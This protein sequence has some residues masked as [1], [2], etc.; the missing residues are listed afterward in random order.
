M[1]DEFEKKEAEESAEEKKHTSSSKRRSRRS[2]SPTFGLIA[3]VIFL[4]LF[5]ALY[6]IVTV[7]SLATVASKIM[8]VLTPVV[9]GFGIAYLLNPL[10]KLYENRLFKG[11]KNKK[12][13]RALG[14]ICTYLTVFLFLGGALFLVAPALI[15]SITVLI[16]NF[17]GYIEHT[18]ELI[19]GLIGKYLDS[20]KEISIDRA[21]LY[22]LIAKLFNTSGDL[23]QSV[24]DYVI[25]YGKGLVV[26]AKNLLFALFISIYVL[27]S[28]EK[29]KANAVKLTTAFLSS[30]PRHRLYKY[31]RLCNKTFGGFFI[32][33]IIDSLIIGA[34]TFVTLYLFD[35]PF[36]ELVSAIVCVTNVIPVFG[37]FIGAIPS[38]FIIFIKD[39]SKAFIF[40]I[41]ILIIQQ[42][43]GNIIGPKILGDSTGMSSLGVMVA[44]L[45]MGD[46][47][48]VIGMI[49]G[50]PIFAVILAIVNEIAENKLRQK[51]LP[52]NTAEYYSSN[53]EAE[54]YTQRETISHAV[55]SFAGHL[56]FKRKKTSEAESDD[57]ENNDQKEE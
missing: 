40:L 4:A 16:A 9:L 27:I 56:I 10:L 25:K 43:D 28:K 44:I 41:I 18:I 35:M 47:L 45:I 11:I 30:G 39:P 31:A 21:Q 38:F 33:K 26:G 24:G 20:H 53:A 15:E 2:D 32:G 50:V 19:N 51:N 13:L 3:I 8:S 49:L 42:I 1:N 12:A 14:L 34:I 22:E 29:L 6:T 36:F 17:D 37:P 23:F 7:S 48:G 55:F 57:K 52:V 46:W 54:I 5:V